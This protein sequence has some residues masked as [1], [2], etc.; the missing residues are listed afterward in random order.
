MKKILFKI[1]FV[2]I[3]LIFSVFNCYS[4]NQ[5]QKDSIATTT[6][7]KDFF[8]WYITSAKENKSGYQP[9]FIEDDN[10]MTTLDYSNYIENLIKHSFSDSLI[11]K[12]K[13]SY[14]E[15]IKNL[16]KLK[17]SDFLKFENL[18]DFESRDCDFSNYYRWIGGQEMSSGYS[19]TKIKSDKGKLIVIGFLFG[20]PENNDKRSFVKDVSVTFIKQKDKW[21]ILIFG[22][23]PPAPLYNH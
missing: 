16:A 19:V 8:N 4:Q 14:S 7:A 23:E 22:I 3:L 17:Y 12:E 20:N 9:E 11:A 13:H 21:K 15:C 18:D 1:I 10:G 5:F 6:I 2:F